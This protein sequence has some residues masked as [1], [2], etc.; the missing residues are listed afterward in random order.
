MDKHAFGGF[1]KPY[2]LFLTLLEISDAVCT[3]ADLAAGRSEPKVAAQ[4]RLQGLDFRNRE[5]R[6]RT[7][8]PEAKMAPV[9][10]PPTRHSDR[11][12][13]YRFS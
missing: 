11:D 4:T 13:Q 9:Q 1:R 3:I 5:L 2:N 7:R 12:H 6:R 10:T 8:P